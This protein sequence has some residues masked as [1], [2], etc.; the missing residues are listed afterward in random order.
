MRLPCRVSKAGSGFSVL[1]QRWWADVAPSPDQSQ[2]TEERVREAHGRDHCP[3]LTQQSTSVGRQLQLAAKQANGHR[4]SIICCELL[5]PQ[6]T[7]TRSDSDR[8]TRQL[9]RRLLFLNNV[10]RHLSSPKQPVGRVF[11]VLLDEF[12]AHSSER[13]RRPEPLPK[14]RRSKPSPTGSRAHSAGDPRTSAHRAASD[15][16][17]PPPPHPKRHALTMQTTTSTIV[18]FPAPLRSHGCWP[19]T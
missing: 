6:T 17:P 4:G 13:L 15:L 7:A 2:K 11:S 10:T 3:I 1:V 8:C 9:T 18:E 12:S 19:S 14:P 16:N 5:S